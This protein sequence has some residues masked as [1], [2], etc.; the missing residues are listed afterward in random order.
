LDTS[1][2]TL[3]AI[4]LSLN[5]ILQNLSKNDVENVSKCTR[6]LMK[7]RAKIGAIISQLNN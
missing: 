7:K 4:I 1:S 3:N 2:K 6:I 5:Q